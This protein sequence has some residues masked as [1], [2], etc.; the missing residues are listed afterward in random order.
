MLASPGI[1]FYLVDPRD[2]LHATVAEVPDYI[3]QAIPWFVILIALEALVSF[4]DGQASRRYNVKETLCSIMTGLAQ[5]V[6]GVPVSAF[7]FAS[8][9]AVYERYRLCS[10]P[11][12]SAACWIALVVGVDL[13]YYWLHRFAHEYHIGWIG[14]SVHHSGEF[15]NM[16]TALRQGIGQGVVSGVF[17]LPLALAGLPP[18]MYRAH[19]IF[20][21]LYQYWIHTELV[22]NLGPLEYVLNTASHHR[23]H[24]RPGANCNYA[25]VLIVWDRLFG[26]FREEGSEQQDRYGLGL[27]AA[28]FEPLALNVQHARRTLAVLGP[29]FLFRRRLA[30]KW[31][32][33]PAALFAP[34]SAGRAALWDVPTKALRPKY[35]GASALPGGAPSGQ[36][37]WRSALEHVYLVAHTGVLILGND[38]FGRALKS[39]GGGAA[40]VNSTSNTSSGGTSGGGGGG[41]G[42]GDG[43]NEA[44]VLLLG[45]WLLLSVLCLGRLSSGHALVAAGGRPT[46]LAA[47]EAFRLLLFALY[48]QP[49]ALS[50]LSF[51]PLGVW[52]LAVV[53]A[54]ASNR[55]TAGVNVR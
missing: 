51:V 33:S 6:A 47:L 37:S 28:S 42:G 4:A 34:L 29:A 1:L 21:L 14:H 39:G 25:G 32:C 46:G 31:V 50:L 20:N 7:W 35:V 53:V 2:H 19:K 40:F 38:A 15:Y 5:Q 3:G 52:L 26:T 16:A 18:A 54:A 43:G 48:I 36:W 41:S 30:A 11:F 24:H 8:Y 13:A 9:I 12:D 55:G 23:V 10:V 49:S 44:L 27:P 22:G 45:A 17:D